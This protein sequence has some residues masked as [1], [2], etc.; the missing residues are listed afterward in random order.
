MSQPPTIQFVP[1]SKLVHNPDNPR[2]I[3]D[4]RF[5]KIRKSIEDFPDMLNFRTLVCV[6]VDDG[7][8]M[9]L[10][11][12]QRLAAMREL[13]IKKAPIMLADH[14][15]EEQRREFI[16]KDNVG[17]GDWDWDA[18]ANDWDVGEL[19][20]WGLDIPIGTDEEGPEEEREI[21]S[22]KV[23]VP[24]YEPTG[25]KPKLKELIDLTKTER[26]IS[27]IEA[28][29]LPKDVKVFLC[30]AA[31]RHTEFHYGKIADY[32]AH[33]DAL[34]KEYM[35]RSALVIVDID[36]AIE[37]GLVKMHDEISEVFKSDYPNA[38]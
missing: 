8:Y 38:E 29:K 14:W 25:K 24:I 17:Y 3:R 31:A 4:E 20:D 5:E 19:S 30:H 13:K 6:S 1:L 23:K 28:S 27:E 10:G 12:N 33:A 36:K 32:Y 37:N 16:I 15:T 18:L 7:K 34:T 9:V 22:G 21:Y 35:E 2:V 26:L 11:G